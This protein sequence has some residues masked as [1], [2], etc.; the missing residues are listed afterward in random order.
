MSDIGFPCRPEYSGESLKDKLKY[1]RLS[2]RVFAKQLML[3]CTA[4]NERKVASMLLIIW[5]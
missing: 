3:L 2:Q 1:R 4:S 5:Q